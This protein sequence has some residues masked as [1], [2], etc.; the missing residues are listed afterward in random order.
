[1]S[2]WKCVRAGARALIVRVVAAAAFA[3][4]AA[5]AQ[6]AAAC[7]LCAIYTGTIMRA[8]RTGAWIGIAEQYTHYGNLKEDGDDIA[9]P[10]DEWMRSSITQIVGGYTFASWIGVQVSVPLISR[11]YRRL[12]DGVA[13]RGDEGGLGDL[14]VLLRLV[15]LTRA[16]TYGVLH[17]EVLAGVKL[18]TGDSDRLAEELA[19]DDHDDE[20]E[21]HALARSVPARAA[22]ARPPHRPHHDEHEHASGV[23]GHDL[24]LGSGSVDGSFGLSL[25]ASWK[26]LFFSAAAQYALR[27]NGAFGYEYADDLLWSAGPGVYPLLGHDYTT[28]LQ[29]V[30]S[31]ETKGNDRQGAATLGDTALTS[32]NLGPGVSLTWKQSL[33]FDLVAELP[34]I[35]NNSGRQVVADYRLRGGLSWH[36]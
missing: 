27:G 20:D 36:F 10:D 4:A 25:F 30:V 35:Q 28:A 33:S 2:N 8:D 6:P 11:E 12:E 21:H 13:T 31:G 29:L 32:V 14:S 5:V 15:P 9:N 19:E 22:M 17:A 34:V 24:A 3:A 1:V 26:R 23:H 7:D 18:P 16:Y